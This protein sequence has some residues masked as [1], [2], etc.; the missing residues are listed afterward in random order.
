M[1]LFVSPS[2]F[3]AK[4]RDPARVRGA[5]SSYSVALITIAGVRL[6]SI[7]VTVL[8][9]FI[10]LREVYTKKWESCDYPTIA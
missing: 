1:T 10:C 3:F 5:K 8:P 4:V 7:L 6:N 9:V 2:L